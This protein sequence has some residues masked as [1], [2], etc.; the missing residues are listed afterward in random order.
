MEVEINEYLSHIKY[1]RRYSQHT[2]IAYRTDLLQFKAYCQ[3]NL[4]EVAQADVRRFLT[5][6]R[7]KKLS[8]RTI[9]RKI[10]VLRSF[11]RYFRR[12]TEYN[13]FPCAHIRL[14][15]FVKPRGKYLP[16]GTIINVLDGIDYKNCKKLLRDRLVLEFLYQTGCRASEVINLRKNQIDI[17][18]KQIRII[19]KGNVERIV[20]ISKRLNKLISQHLKCWKTKN[21][22]PYLFTNDTGRKMYSMFLWRLI[23]K[24]FPE[25]NV[26]AHTLRHSCATH[27]Y[28]NR[29]PIKAIRDLLGHR[30]LRSTEVYLHHDIGHLIKVYTDSHPRTR[31]VR[32]QREG[33]CRIASRPRRTEGSPRSE[34]ASRREGVSKEREVKERNVARCEL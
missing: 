25:R 32:Q 28:H 29:A 10:E 26:S 11:Y 17:H 9:N 23:K 16:K 21:R 1:V 3:K 33:L 20:P 19:G 12:F 34:S 2:F 13:E 30:A 5:Y 22:T 4:L 31:S 6:L 15:R 24:Y 7:E 18:R 14:L 27:L 8:P